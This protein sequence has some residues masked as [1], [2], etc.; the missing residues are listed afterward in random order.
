MEILSVRQAEITLDQKN[1]MT[2]LHF[3]DTANE[4]EYCIIT[5]E[6]LNKWADYAKPGFRLYSA[7]ELG[8]SIIGRKTML[9]TESEL[10]TEP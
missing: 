4:N 10:F 8:E 9:P 1:Q 7:H 2:L 6:P 5:D 3:T